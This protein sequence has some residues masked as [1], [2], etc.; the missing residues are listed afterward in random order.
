LYTNFVFWVDFVAQVQCLTLEEVQILVKNQVEV[1]VKDHV[2][3]KAENHLLRDQIISLNSQIMS[4][5]S[6]KD[7]ISSLKMEIQRLTDEVTRLSSARDDCPCDLT[8]IDD[9]LKE[10]S[11]DITNLRVD[12]GLL[13][14]YRYL[15]LCSKRSR[16]N[17]FC[18]HATSCKALTQGYIL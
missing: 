7:D 9:W 12:A 17:S 2:D 18:D 16:N 6:A 14:D 1:L 5:S 4:F 3:L 8:Y 11:I 13:N 10:N 15:S